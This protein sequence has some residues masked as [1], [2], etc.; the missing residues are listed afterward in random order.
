MALWIQCASV[1]AYLNQQRG[2]VCPERPG[3][4]GVMDADAETEGVY[5]SLIKKEQVLLSSTLNTAPIPTGCGTQVFALL[6]LSLN[7]LIWPNWLS[8]AHW[9]LNTVVVA[10]GRSG[11][12]LKE[13]QSQKDCPR[14]K[15]FT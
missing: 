7:H 5:L 2:S 10:W 6:G 8:I 13:E 11:F 3:C 9:S 12:I 1:R 15:A 4:P 14:G